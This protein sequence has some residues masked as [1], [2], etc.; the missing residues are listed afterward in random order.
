MPI[1]M[2]SLGIERTKTGSGS[3]TR[4]LIIPECACFQFL[5]VLTVFFIMLLLYVQQAKID[6]WNHKHELMN[7][8]RKAELFAHDASMTIMGLIVDLEAHIAHEIEWNHMEEQLVERQNELQEASRREINQIVYASVQELGKKVEEELSLGVQ[9]HND[10]RTKVHN[11]FGTEQHTMNAK[12]S[13]AFEE[14]TTQTQNLNKVYLTR[15]QDE[16]NRNKEGLKAA[17]KMI[18][19]FAMINGV[20]KDGMPQE[21]LD[22]K[23]N[24][25]YKNVEKNGKRAKGIKLPKK[26]VKEIEMLLKDFDKLSV[27]EVIKRMTKLLFPGGK[28]EGKPLFGVSKYQGGSLEA[29]LENVLFLQ[30]FKTQLYPTLLD[31]KD[32]WESRELS[33]YDLLD[34]ILRMVEKSVLPATWLL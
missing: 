19:Q 12:M 17:H 25:F 29:Y 4:A 30:D 26:A 6:Y 18:K 10:V 7:E 33:S 32:R 23:I 5:G 34:E 16:A 9:G 14:Y 15:I 31:K 3:K 21:Q 2:P 8:K 1:V 24:L 11:V 20:A 28:N 27:E 13:A 22:Y